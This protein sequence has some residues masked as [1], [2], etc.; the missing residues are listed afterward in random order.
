MYETDD[1][2]KGPGRSGFGCARSSRV[3]LA[4]AQVA[5]HSK[6]GGPFRVGLHRVWMRLLLT[7]DAES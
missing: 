4:R 7:F 3:N 5:E 1:F 2:N 6:L